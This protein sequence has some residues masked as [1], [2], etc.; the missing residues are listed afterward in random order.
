MEGVRQMNIDLD[1]TN[2]IL[3][4]L[5]LKDRIGELEHQ[6]RKSICQSCVN[7]TNIADS[8]EFQIECLTTEIERLKTSLKTH[9]LCDK[10]ILI[11]SLLLENS[12]LRSERDGYLDDAKKQKNQAN[13]YL[14][15]LES[16]K[17][18]LKMQQ[19]FIKGIG[20][21]KAYNDVF[22]KQAI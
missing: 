20:Q 4:I 18:D 2:A 3:E 19:R 10:Q 16:T 12:H 22:N 17:K 9:Q 14:N 5:K 8:Q 7:M 13:Y 6:A 1:Q 21:V 15:L 11:D